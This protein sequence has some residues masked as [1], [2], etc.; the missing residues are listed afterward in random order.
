MDGLIVDTQCPA[1]NR[2]ASSQVQLFSGAV[3]VPGL[4][5]SELGPPIPDHGL[6]PLCSAHTLPPV[7]TPWPGSRVSIKAKGARRQQ[8]GGKPLC[9]GPGS[10]GGMG[11]RR[12]LPRRVLC[13]LAPAG[14]RQGLQRTRLCASGHLQPLTR[15]PEVRDGATL[16]HLPGLPRSLPKGLPT[17]LHFPPMQTQAKAGLLPEPR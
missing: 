14:E 3:H 6:G 9:Q 16:Q 15:L 1:T 17:S 2:S 11:A 7:G 8:L 5:G 12:R 13:A 4:W 10:H